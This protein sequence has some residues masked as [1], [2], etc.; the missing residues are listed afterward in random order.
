MIV[1]IK[2]VPEY[3]ELVGTDKLKISGADTD[4]SIMPLMSESG[5]WEPYIQRLCCQF[6]KLNNRVVD[7]GANYGTHTALMSKLVGKHGKVFA[8][9]ASH[10]NCEHLRRTLELNNCVDNVE[11]LE[12]AAGESG[13]GTFCHIDE[14]AACSY[15]ST[16]QHKHEDFENTTAL[17]QLP[18]VSLDSLN[19][20]PV[21]FIK[22]D[23]EGSELFAFRGMKTLLKNLPPMVVELNAT[24]SERFFNIPIM[25]VVDYLLND[26]GYSKMAVAVGNKNGNG[27]TWSYIPYEMLRNTFDKGAELIDTL[28][29]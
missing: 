1:D 24:T 5:Q 11:I 27:S 14:N 13:E 22:I 20:E 25:D 29:V 26:I 6:I 18:F 21:N 12:I 3:Q 2:I 23:I 17:Q 4:K 19:I 15:F 16:T 7:I 8:I 9:E 28:F 10:N